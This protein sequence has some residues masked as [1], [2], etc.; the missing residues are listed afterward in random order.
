MFTGA[1]LGILMLFAFLV[2]GGVG[3]D[4]IWLWKSFLNLLRT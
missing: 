2:I 1:V 4:L 3:L